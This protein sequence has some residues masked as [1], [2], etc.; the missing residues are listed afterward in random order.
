MLL[1]LRF[2]VSLAASLRSGTACKSSTVTAYS[3]SKDTLFAVS[4]TI[5]ALADITRARRNVCCLFRLNVAGHM[6]P[7]MCLLALQAK[8]PEK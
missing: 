7:K 5:L 6:H 1:I 2:R 8:E 4:R 3:C